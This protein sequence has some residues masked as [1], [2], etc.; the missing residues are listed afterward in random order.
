MSGVQTI[1][2][3]GRHRVCNSSLHGVPGMGFKLTGDGNYDVGGK[4]LTN[5]ALSKHDSDGANKEYLRKEIRRIHDEIIYIIN[6]GNESFS[7]FTNK[8][9]RQI[10]NYEKILDE[11]A[12]KIVK[13]D[14]NRIYQLEIEVN[15]LRKLIRKGWIE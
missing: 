12:I 14:D 10:T 11:D 7:E 13:L 6:K 3:F 9:G 2:K 5:I 1:D 8:I 15:I 4:L